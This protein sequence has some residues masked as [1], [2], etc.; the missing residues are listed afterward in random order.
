MNYELFT[1]ETIL[2]Q[3]G[4]SFECFYVFLTVSQSIYK[5]R[6]LLVCKQKARLRLRFS[7]SI[8]LQCFSLCWSTLTQLYWDF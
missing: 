2:K 7:F 5:S 1:K 8:L 3:T 6:H 4:P